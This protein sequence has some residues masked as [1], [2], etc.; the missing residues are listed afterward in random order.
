[1]TMTVKVR[2]R[3]PRRVFTFIS[4]NVVLR[5]NDACIVQTDR[6]PEWGVCILPPEP[7]PEEMSERHSMRVLRRADERDEETMA[8]MLAEEWRAFD[9]CRKKIE[10]H[11]MPMKLVDVEVSFDKR[12][13]VFLFTADDRVD[14]RELVRDLA[15]DL[16]TRIEM[17]HIQVRDEAGI[18][19]GLGG[20]GRELCCSS[21]LTEF[22]PISMRMAKKQNLSLN[23]SKISGQC[24]RLLCCLAYENDQY[25]QAKKRRKDTPQEIEVQ[26]TPP[27]RALPEAPGDEY[28]A[29]LQQELAAAAESRAPK[30]QGRGGQRDDRPGNNRGDRPGNQRQQ[31]GPRPERPERPSPPQQREIRP[32]PPQPPAPRE[33]TA[34][35]EGAEAEAQGDRAKK[36][37]G[38]RSHRRG[39]GGPRPGGTA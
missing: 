32:A 39:K 12:K 34:A 4:D 22:K 18:V 1:M 25:E 33:Q 8:W 7:M 19:G 37:R 14:F 9:I 13:V 27:R 20:C 23:P 10:Q 35:P 16:R 6:G 36:R 29:T 24:G 3:K 2:L 21:W 38:G 28:S 30:P 26:R 15:H 17:R 31:G 11:R 5:R